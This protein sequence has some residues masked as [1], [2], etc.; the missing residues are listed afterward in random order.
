MD[1]REQMLVKFRVLRKKALR[2]TVDSLEEALGIPAREL[3]LQRGN[4][5][6][7]SNRLTDTI[8]EL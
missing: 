5:Q 8:N 1:W 7:L 4:P 6:H 3:E 2:V